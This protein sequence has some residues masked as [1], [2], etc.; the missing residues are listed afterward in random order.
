MDDAIEQSSRNLIPLMVDK[1]KAF[2]KN[3]ILTANY[4]APP[5][6]SLPT[7]PDEAFYSNNSIWEKIN[8]GIIRRTDINIILDSF[9]LFEWFPRSPGLYYTPT[10][11]KA[12][13]EA[14]SN[15]ERIDEGVLVYNPYGK[16][17][18][19]EGGIGNIRLKPI[20]I[21]NEFCNVFSF[22]VALHYFFET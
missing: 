6:L 5:S 2:L 1:F 17:S 14:Q 8:Y 22:G 16:S 10:G 3:H 19:L 18:M 20:K 13:R 12:R 11:F 21:D 7:S 15:I 4:I 9:F